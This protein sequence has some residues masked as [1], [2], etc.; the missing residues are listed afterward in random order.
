MTSRPAVARCRR[1][2]DDFR[3]LCTVGEDAVDVTKSFPNRTV[4][5]RA[6]VSAEPVAQSPVVTSNRRRGPNPLPNAKRPTSG[7]P[8]SGP[9][10]R[11]GPASGSTSTQPYDELWSTTAGA[12]S[13]TSTCQRFADVCSRFSTRGLRMSPADLSVRTRDERRVTTPANVIACAPN[14][15]RCSSSPPPRV[16][17]SG[18]TATTRVVLRK[19]RRITR[20]EVQPTPATHQYRTRQDATAPSRPSA[21]NRQEATATSSTVEAFAVDDRAAPSRR[22]LS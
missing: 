19:H 8:S 20:R 2:Q 10:H 9:A 11:Y 1:E 5:R 12:V 15:L 16:R 13:R 6:C 7:P 22:I 18:P 3:F 4:L 21:W 17:M 14:G